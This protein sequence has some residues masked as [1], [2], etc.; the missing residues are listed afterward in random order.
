MVAVEALLGECLWV[1]VRGV[2]S[3]GDHAEGI[4]YYPPKQ[5][6]KA[7]KEIFGSI[8]QALGQQ[9]MFIWV[10][11]SIQTFGFWWPPW[12][13]GPTLQP[14]LITTPEPLSA[15]QFP[16]ILSQACNAH[17]VVVPQVT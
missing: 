12:P 1:K 3:K 6:D 7:N 4:C 14:L 16:T 9:N 17:G 2:L 15:G 11:T 13:L 10:T 5:D 8:K